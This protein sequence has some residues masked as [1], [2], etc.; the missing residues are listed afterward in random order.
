MPTVEHLVY[1]PT[2]EAVL[3]ISAKRLVGVTG[4]WGNYEQTGAEEL[5]YPIVNFYYRV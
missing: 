1:S 3:Y 5:I 2:S 4:A